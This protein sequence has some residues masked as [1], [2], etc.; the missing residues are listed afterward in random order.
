MDGSVS[1]ERAE[2]GVLFVDGIGGQRPG[3]AVASLGAALFGWL[4]RW[5]RS[6]SLS[7]Q[8]APSLGKAVLSADA[9][10][11]GQPAHLT[12]KTP[13]CLSSGK[14]QAH[15][16]LAESSWAGAHSPP[17]FL[18]LGRWIWKVS[19]CLLVLQFV[20]PMRRHWRQYKC[21]AASGVRLMRRLD[22]AAASL[23]YLALMGLA[24]M[25]SVLLSIVLLALAM[26][27]LLPIPRIDRAVKWVVVRLSAILGDSY[28]L[29]HCPVQ[30]AAMRTKVADDLRWLQQRC[31][32]VAV[33]A[34]SQGAAIAH[35][36]LRDARPASEVRAF[37]TVGQGISKLHLLQR[38]DWDPSGRRAARRSRSFVVTGLLLAG[39]PALG[40]L[41]SRF[42]VPALRILDTSVLYPPQISA[43][44][45]SLAFGV[46]QAVR[47]NGRQVD[48]SLALRGVAAHQSW[49]DYYA[50]A[51]PVSNGRLLPEQASA[52]EEQDPHSAG[53]VVPARCHEIYNKGSVITD[54]DS[55]LDNQDQ[56]LSSLLND[57]VAAAY[58]HNHVSG[59]DPQLVS[60][61]DIEEVS[62]RRK[63]LLDW[64]VGARVLT[65]ALGIVLWE[66]T[67]DM[68]LAGPVDQAMHV[69]VLQAAVGNL[70]ARLGVIALAMIVAYVVV[71]VIPWRIM[72]NRVCR[73]FFQSAMRY[74][75][76]THPEQT[77]VKPARRLAELLTRPRRRRFAAE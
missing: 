71:G 10:G 5:N 12:L 65:L 66:L 18:D 73:K 7:A 62:Q 13:L 20:I 36:V 76:L 64:L 52:E 29:A 57:L 47:A 59:A 39:L 38:M 4:F 68:S 70:T 11:A 27:A 16:L 58:G 14:R 44:L 1:G 23:C 48:E 56:F 51:D 31:E 75:D 41:A 42:G 25:L 45:L 72:E 37:I 19:T 77:D 34:H 43:G 17:R 46:W 28:M 15:W 9:A 63:R 69:V 2:F 22:S 21:D 50:S 40:V 74:D 8:D 3:S 54:H 26:A 55:Y 49:T 32:V 35:Q 24:A 30:F 61:G 6:A 33:V 67:A 60:D 53:Y